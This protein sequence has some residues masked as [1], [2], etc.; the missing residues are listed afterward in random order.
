VN[1]TT[2][3]HPRLALLYRLVLRQGGEWTRARVGRAY[4][5]AGYRAPQHRT[6]KRDL[7]ALHRM[8]VLDLH[9]NTGF[10]YYTPRGTA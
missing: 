6:H 10:R 7:K 5:A 3:L 8:G 4:A 1:A 2:A 9:D